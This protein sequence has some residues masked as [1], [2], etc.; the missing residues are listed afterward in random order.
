MRAA[1]GQLHA[2]ILLGRLELG[3]HSWIRK[4]SLQEESARC[5]R[6]DRPTYVGQLQDALLVF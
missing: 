1:P 2:H 6:Q 5:Q 4:H 3:Q